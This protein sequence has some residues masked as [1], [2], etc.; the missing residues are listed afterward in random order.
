MIM[1]IRLIV[2]T[3]IAFTYPYGRAV[4][5][6][7]VE[8]SVVG[9]LS[10]DHLFGKMSDS[11]NSSD[12]LAIPTELVGA[13]DAR[14][15]IRLVPAGM[16]RWDVELKSESMT[17]VREAD[18]SG[19]FIRVTVIDFDKA[20]NQTLD[21]FA[22]LQPV[23]SDPNGSR[24]FIGLQFTGL[25]LAQG[26]TSLH[27][28]MVDRRPMNCFA[29]GQIDVDNEVNGGKDKPLP[30]AEVMPSRASLHE[31]SVGAEPATAKHL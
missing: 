15:V 1:S 14:A 27:I 8:L 3:V 9:N 13:S 5:C 24:S 6:D 11:G 12:I 31:A 2:F 28:S 22:V 25:K 17:P 23:S 16:N 20:G 7:T 30:I 18:E 26:D 21:Q 19:K 29:Q 10:A 4:A